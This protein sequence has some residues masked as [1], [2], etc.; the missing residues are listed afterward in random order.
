MTSSPKTV[1]ALALVVG[2]GAVSADTSFTATNWITSVPVPGILCTNASAQVSLKGNV[3]VL[4][5]VSDDA[6]IAGRMTAWM[7]LAYQA[8]GAAIFS[9]PAYGEVGS[10]DGTGTKFTPAGGVW[11]LRYTGLAQPDGSDAIR[12]TGY[13]IGGAIEGLRV[14]VTC[15]K[16]PGVPFDPAVPYYASGVIKS[17]PLNTRTLV[18]DFSDGQPWDHG[19]AGLGKP[20][21]DESGG[22]YTL[23]GD[24]RGVSTWRLS[25]TTAWMT[26]FTA[27]N[28]PEGQTIETRVEL[29]GMND[30]ATGVAL[31]L[32]HA[33]GQCYGLSKANDWVALWKQDAV[34]V[35]FCCERVLTSN[36]NVVLS[37]ALTP[38]GS[39]LA[40]TGRVLDKQTGAVLYQRICVDTPAADASLSQAELATAT[41][42]R[43]WH[44]WGSDPPGTPWRSGTSACLFVFQDTDGSKLP[45]TATFDNLELLHYEIPRV[46]ITR[47][48]QLSCP[49]TGMRFEVEGAHD[50]EG[51]YLPIRDSL[52]PGLEQMVVPQDDLIRFIQLRQ[53]P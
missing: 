24:W 18:D 51:P 50:V 44:D 2:A 11:D 9:G 21:N 31:T 1:L 19:S 52:Q 48:V 7:D 47:A 39:S 53:A 4:R 43:V 15:T 6:R 20:I 45:A 23:G 14:E 16:E 29:A 8:N 32:Y 37:L 30:S 3:H 42:C 28:V 40:L 49:A 12:M 13:G 26:M 22:R 46:V 10:W 33:T 38:T 41:G 35:A 25:D 27:W 17:A 5:L 34:L 36:T